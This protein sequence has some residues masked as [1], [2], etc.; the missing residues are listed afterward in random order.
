MFQGGEV[1][2]GKLILFLRPIFSPE[3]WSILGIK[4]SEYEKKRNEKPQ[5][6]ETPVFEA[7][8]FKLPE[9]RQKDDTLQP[10]D[11]RIEYLRRHFRSLEDQKNLAHEMISEARTLEEIASVTLTINAEGSAAMKSFM[12]SIELKMMNIEKDSKRK[13]QVEEELRI[14]EKRLLENKKKIDAQQK[15]KE[16]LKRLLERKKE[17]IRKRNPRYSE[18]RR[19][20]PY[21]DRYNE[22]YTLEPKKSEE[23]RSL[24]VTIEKYKQDIEELRE[25]GLIHQNI[26]EKKERDLS[27]K[28]INFS[29]E[30]EDY[31]QAS[32]LVK[33]ELSR[34]KE[35]QTNLGVDKVKIRETSNALNRLVDAIEKHASF[36]KEL[37]QSKEALLQTEQEEENEKNK[38]K[39]KEDVRTY[40]LE[41]ERRDQQRD[42][43]KII[44][45]FNQSSLEQLQA[46]NALFQSIKDGINDHITSSEG[47]RYKLTDIGKSSTSNDLIEA[48]RAISSTWNSSFYASGV[49]EQYLKLLSKGANENLI[50]DMFSVSPFISSLDN[51]VNRSM[52]L[53]SSSKTTYMTD[54]YGNKIRITE[55]ESY[56]DNQINQKVSALEAR[57]KD[58]MIREREIERKE[59]IDP[60]C[61]SIQE[62]IAK[63][64]FLSFNKQILV[65]T[66][67]MMNIFL[68]RLSNL[69]QKFLR[70]GSGHIDRLIADFD[71]R[72]STMQKE[73]E[74]YLSSLREKLRKKAEKEKEDERDKD[75][76]KYENVIK[77]EDEKLQRKIDDRVSNLFASL[78]LDIINI[79]RGIATTS[80]HEHFDFIGKKIRRNTF[81]I[82]KWRD[83]PSL[84]IS[85]DEFRDEL[86]DLDKARYSISEAARAF[87][88]TDLIEL[89]E[90][91]I[92]GLNMNNAKGKD[93][94]NLIPLRSQMRIDVG[95]TFDTIFLYY[96]DRLRLSDFVFDREFVLLYFL[97]V[98]NFSF[99]IFSLYITESI[100][101]DQY[102]KK[103]YHRKEKPP[104][105]IYL[106]LLCYG[107][108][109]IM[110]LVLIT[111]L[112]LI[113]Y[114]FAEN[115]HP[116]VVNST[117]LLHYLRDYIGISLT[118][119]GFALLFA[120]V[121]EKKRYFRYQIEG[122]RTIRGLSE[123]MLYLAVFIYVIPM[124]F[125]FW[126]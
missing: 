37:I 39:N 49:Q 48:I 15:E 27:S 60:A 92:D 101:N 84:N 76:D 96:N 57:E 12:N 69:H 122:L 14:E 34:T 22:P 98:V 43:D 52:D 112:I 55:R 41:G 109:T 19:Y 46:S 72:V 6:T 123:V 38:S 119:L 58:L 50:E 67:R 21:N 68:E 83:D 71:G 115:I 125:V 95:D 20:Y 81:Y 59:K 45:D 28:D 126:T 110:N 63:K 100:F 124:F 13:K 82:N 18:Q 64:T 90:N 79:I 120:Y 75:K 8:N 89:F 44:Q 35:F 29:S 9:P 40:I 74:E 91:K 17:E 32:S 77:A 23:L 93:R 5:M 99:L 104:S 36:V 106:V 117:L 87:L 103:V 113:A 3:F 116:F 80:K 16:S 11:E 47:F 111:I 118:H 30:Q 1:F 94:E 53:G 114:T 121:A 61:S 2:D 10:L 31:Q 105:L 65:K 85:T 62:T 66:T 7:T 97:K 102:I 108:H 24:E 56:K 107:I 26:I 51:F 78:H 33:D 88:K 70:D 25:K 73:K 4:E 86:S 42:E 54:K